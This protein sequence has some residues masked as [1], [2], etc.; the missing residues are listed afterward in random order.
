MILQSKAAVVTGST[1][2]I[3]LAIA[4]AL[5]REGANVMI[6]GLGDPGQIEATRAG[7]EAEFGVRALYSGADMTR[8]PEIAAMVAEAEGAFGRLDVLVNNAGIQ[9]VSPVEEFP[10]EKWD[11]ILAINLSSAFHTI[12]AAVPGMKARG[13]GR[14]VNIASAHSLVASPFKSAYVAAKHG[15]VGMTKSVALE[16]ATHG[17]TVNCISPG[18]VWT[19]LVESQIPDTMKARNMT[20]EQVIEEV[21][22][23]AQPT[24]EFVTVDQVAAIAVFLCS[25]AATQ[26]TGAN[27]SVDGGW[28]AQ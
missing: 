26:M 14:I 15:L 27:L 22:L 1:S 9:Y 12:R 11:A 13:F 4:K 5:A 6:N 21:L 19:P 20:K 24:K 28:T 23:K 8:P 7:I 18:Y 3:G 16:L 17:V 25:D 10:P 2:G